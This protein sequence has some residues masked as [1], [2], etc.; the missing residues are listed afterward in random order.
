M[1]SDHSTRFA[2]VSIRLY[3]HEGAFDIGLDADH[4]I[5]AVI[6]AFEKLGCKV[7]RNQTRRSL[8]VTC[9][10]PAS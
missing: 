8:S 10:E 9:P 3:G 5:E 7:V 1:L 4:D 6:L 2:E